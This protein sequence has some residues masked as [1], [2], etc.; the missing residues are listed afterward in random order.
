MLQ[1][2]LA[3][4]DLWQEYQLLDKLLYKNAN[5]HHSSQHFHALQEVTAAPQMRCWLADPPPS[6]PLSCCSLSKV[7]RL[8]KLLKSM[9]LEQRASSF[10]AAFQAGKQRGS[11]PLGSVLMAQGYDGWLP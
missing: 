9:H 5:Q 6:S 8:L 7:R 1:G 3:R 11:L 10:H 2:A 4:P